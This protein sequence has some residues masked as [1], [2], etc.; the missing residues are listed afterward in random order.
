MDDPLIEEEKKG[1]QLRQSPAGQGRDR[2]RRS[3]E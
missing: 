3:Q 2:E 1:K